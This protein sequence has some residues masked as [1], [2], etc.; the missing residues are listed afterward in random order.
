MSTL[1]IE[2]QEQHLTDLTAL[3]EQYGGRILHIEHDLPL[4]KDDVI[5]ES[6][7]ASTPL[8]ILDKMVEQVKNHLETGGKNIRL[9]KLLES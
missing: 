5:W 8:P 2:I 3:L 4:S 6:K 7:L 9:E 1:T